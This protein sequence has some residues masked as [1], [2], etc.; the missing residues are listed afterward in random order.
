MPEIIFFFKIC[1]QNTTA[2]T[3]MFTEKELERN[4]GLHFTSYLSIAI[5]KILS[6]SKAIKNVKKLSV[7]SKN[8]Y[9]RLSNFLQTNIF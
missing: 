9:G 7:F 4:F 5:L 8:D 3:E 1:W 6:Y 2:S